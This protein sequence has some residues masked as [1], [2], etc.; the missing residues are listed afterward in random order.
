MGSR[1]ANFIGTIGPIFQSAYHCA[2]LQSADA[3][4]LT[5]FPRSRGVEQRTAGVNDRF[6][7]DPSVR[8]SCR[9]GQ[10]VKRGSRESANAFFRLLRYHAAEFRQNRHRRRR[11]A[12]R[13]AFAP[14]LIYQPDS[15]ILAAMKRCFRLVPI[16]AYPYCPKSDFLSVDNSIYS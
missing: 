13:R 16:G 12:V 11:L 9:E 1:P 8:Q 4:H 2:K 6:P 3:A 7:P 14:M 10:P 15:G 5:A